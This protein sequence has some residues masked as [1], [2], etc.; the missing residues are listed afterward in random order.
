MRLL[1]AQR[2]GYLPQGQLPANA[3]GAWHQA[4]KNLKRDAM[5]AGQPN[6]MAFL[7]NMIQGG[8]QHPVDN[9]TPPLIQP[10]QGV[11]WGGHQFSNISDLIGWEQKHGNK[12]D[13]AQFMSQH[14]ALVAL[15]DRLQQQRNSYGRPPKGMRSRMRPQ[16]PPNPLLDQQMNLY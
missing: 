15:F 7:R 16:A 11:Q 10:P 14:P 6:P 4:S 1:L 13:D 2:A 3:Q 5:K 9:G 12:T 8:M